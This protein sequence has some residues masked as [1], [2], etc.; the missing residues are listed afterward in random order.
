MI[1]RSI[2]QA[3]LVDID[4]SAAPRVV[5]ARGADFFHHGVNRVSGYCAQAADLVVDLRGL[6]GTAAGMLSQHHAWFPIVLNAACSPAMTYRHCAAGSSDLAL[7]FHHRG[8]FRAEPLAAGHTPSAAKR[9]K[10]EIQREQL[11]RFPSG[12]RRRCSRSRRCNRSKRGVFQLSS[13]I[14]PAPLRL[15][16]KN[17]RRLADLL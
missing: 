10:R 1:T 6:H 5:G 11:K 17:H 8:H 13:I 16:R 15:R 3:R 2:N 7:D 4:L 14:P 12:A 9:T